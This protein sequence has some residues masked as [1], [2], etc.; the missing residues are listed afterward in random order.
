MIIHVS[1]FFSC[2]LLLFLISPHLNFSSPLAPCCISLTLCLFIFCLLFLCIIWLLDLFLLHVLRPFASL[3]LPLPP[4]F[5][6]LL[7]TRSPS[8]SVLFFLC[9]I[10]SLHLSQIT[11]SVAQGRVRSP[12]PQPRYKSYAY[13]QAAYVKSPEQKRR[14]SE[15]QVIHNFNSGDK[16]M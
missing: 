9:P 14:L 8:S 10:L 4:L 3:F 16:K 11:V 7:P 13:T 15:G 1:F 12:S 2:F 5:W 6:P